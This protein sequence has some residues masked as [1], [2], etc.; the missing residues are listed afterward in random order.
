MKRETLFPT[1]PI[2]LLHDDYPI[3]M[4]IEVD[5]VDMEGELH[6][7]ADG[8]FVISEMKYGGVETG[9]DMFFLG[10][11]VAE[12]VENVANAEILFTVKEGSKSIQRSVKYLIPYAAGLIV[13]NEGK[14]ESLQTGEKECNT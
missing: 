7:L 9:I 10:K 4:C 2:D 14:K 6:F 1:S 12:V 8:T 11:T 5:G 3:A 13:A